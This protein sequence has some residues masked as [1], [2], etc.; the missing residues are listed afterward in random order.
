MAKDLNASNVS[1]AVP[2]DGLVNT[3]ASRAYV[4]EVASRDAVGLSVRDATLVG[5][6]LS[7]IVVAENDEDLEAFASK[8]SSAGVTV[9]QIELPSDPA[10]RSKLLAEWSGKL[11]RKNKKGLMPLLLLPLAACGG[12][13]SALTFLVSEADGNLAFDGTAIG[14]VSVEVASNGDMSFSRGG[15]SAAQGTISV[16]DVVSAPEAILLSNDITGMGISDAAKL[17]EID[18]FSANGKSIELI[19]TVSNSASGLLTVDAAFG[20][21]DASALTS[22]TGSAADLNA[23]YASAGIT[24]LGN[25]AVTVSDAAL[26]AS[27]LNTLDANTSGSVNASS[28]TSLTG[29]AAE[30]NVAYASAGITGLGNEAVTLTDGSLGA[31]TL[32]TVN[33][34]TTGVVSAASVTTLTG[35][36]VDVNA[37]YTANTA[38]EIS[39]LGNEAVTLT[40][41]SLGA[42]TLNTVNGNTTGVVNAASVTTLT[43][44]AVDVNAAYTANTAGEISG[45]GNEAVTLTDGSLSSDT[46]SSVATKTTGALNVEGAETVTGSAASISTLIGSGRVGFADDVD[47]TISAGAVVASDLI[48]MNDA[49][50]GIVDARDVTTI[51]GTAADILQILG[52]AGIANPVTFT[53]KLVAGSNDATDVTGLF[54]YDAVALVNAASVTNLTGSIAEINAVLDHQNITKPITMTATIDAGS[55]AASDLTAL[56]AEANVTSVSAFAVTTLTGTLT[57][58]NAVLAEGNIANPITMTATIDAGSVAASDLT[59]LLAEANVTSVSAAAVTSLTGTAAAVLSVLNE[60]NIT[61]PTSATVTISAG[62]H[63][64]ADLS[65]I[66]AAGG[67][68]S[69]DASAATTLTGTATEIKALYDAGVTFAANVNFVVNEAATAAQLE[70]IDGL[71][72]GTLSANLAGGETALDLSGATTSINTIVLNDDGVTV[73]GSSQTDVITVGA[74]ADTLNLGDGADVVIIDGVGHADGDVINTEGGNDQINVSGNGTITALEAITINGGADTDTLIVSDTNDFT[75]STI[76]NVEIEVRSDV[77][78]TIDQIAAAGGAIKVAADVAGDTSLSHAIT[79]KAAPGGATSVTITKLQGITSLTVDAGVSVTL[80]DAAAT[81]IATAAALAD[82]G[83]TTGITLDPTSTFEL[84]ANAKATLTAGLIAPADLKY[85]IADDT[86]SILAEQLADATYIGGAVGITVEDAIA[87]VDFA[88][89]SAARGAGINIVLDGGISDTAANLAPAGAV[90]ARLTNAVTQDPDVAITV[91]GVAPT[92]AEVNAIAGAT[93]GAVTATLSVND[94]ATLGGLNTGSGDAISVIVTD[95]SVDAGAAV[96][97]AGKTSLNVDATA[98]SEI[99][100]TVANIVAATTTTSN[101]LL[102]GDYTVVAADAGS[103]A[104]VN[105]IAAATTGVVTVTLGLNTIANLGLLATEATDAVTVVVT[106]VR[107]AASDLLAIDGKTSVAVNA[108]QVE[109]ITGTVAELSAY[110]DAFNAR[111]ISGKLAY[112]VVA[113]D[114]TDDV[115]DL[116]HLADPDGTNFDPDVYLPALTSMTGSAS[117][118]IDFYNLTNVLQNESGDALGDEAVTLT[119]TTL[120]ADVLN[121][122]DTKTTGLV[123][124]ST[125]TTLTGAAADM[126]TAYASAG[127]TGLGDEAATLSDVALDAA[128]LETLVGNTSGAINASSILTLTGAASEIIAAINAGVS[129]KAD[130][131]INVDEPASAADISTIADITTGVVT[132]TSSTTAVADLLT[133]LTTDGTTDV[134]SITVSDTSVDAANLNAI[135]AL[136]AAAAADVDFAAVTELTG[137]ADAIKT[138][139][140]ANGV[141]LTL[142]GTYDIVAS[143]DTSVADIN[144]IVGLTAGAGATTGTITATAASSDATELAGL[145]T[146]DARGDVIAITVTGSATGSELNTISG[147]TT[148]EVTA[149]GVTA[150]TGSAGAIALAVADADI[151]MSGS[152][153]VTVDAPGA[154]ASELNTIFQNTTG[155]VTATV[156]TQTFVGA[157]NLATLSI[158][159]D[160]AVPALTVTVAD[161]TANAADLTALQVKTSVNVDAT[162]TVNGIAGSVSEIDALIASAVDLNANYNLSLSNETLDI[163]DAIRLDGENG[164]GG[165]LVAAATTISGTAS[166]LAAAINSP[167]I[168]VP[169]G[170]SFVVEAEPA[171][172]ATAASDLDTIAAFA[173]AANAV[174]TSAISTVEGAAATLDNLQGYASIASGSTYAVTVNNGA[175]SDASVSAILD[176]RAETS[177]VI[178]ATVTEG[179]PATLATLNDGV[180]QDTNENDQLTISVGAVA[181][182]AADLLKI[183]GATGLTVG[184]TAATS[185]TGS[186]ADVLAALQAGANFG[187]PVSVAVTITGANAAASDINAIDALTTGGIDATAVGTLSGSSADVVSAWAAATFGA[188][189]TVTTTEGAMTVAEFNV[190]NA[191]TSGVITATIDVSTS[192]EGVDALDDLVSNAP[193]VENV[194]TIAVS[195]ADLDAQKLADLVTVTSLGVDASGV[196]SVVGDVTSVGNLNDVSEDAGGAI[197]A[198]KVALSTSLVAKLSNNSIDIDVALVE[199]G[200]FPGVFDFSAATAVTAS[201]GAWEQIVGILATDPEALTFA[202]ATATIK[203]AEAPAIVTTIDAGVLKQIHDALSTVDA[204]NVTEITGSASDLA[205]LTSAVAVPTVTLA[206]NVD[207]EP[208]EAISV[209]LANALTGLSGTGNVLATIAETDIATLKTLSAADNDLTITVADTQVASVDLLA[210]NAATTLEIDAT[211]VTRVN[212]SL[213]DALLLKADVEGDEIAGLTGARFY[214]SD[215][216]SNLVTDVMQ[217][218]NFTAGRVYSVAETYVGLASDL[219]DTGNAATFLGAINAGELITNSAFN[220]RLSSDANGASADISINADVLANL[221]PSM[222]NFEV[223][224]DASIVSQITGSAQAIAAIVSNNAI[225]LDGNY[226]V[227]LN[228]ATA[229]PADILTILNDTIGAIDADGTGVGVT[230]LIG[231]AQ[232]AADVFTARDGGLVLDFANVNVEVTDTSIAAS[233]VTSLSTSNGAGNVDI[234][235]ATLVTG[236]AAQAASVATEAPPQFIS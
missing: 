229:D 130:V 108:G 224:V 168:S 25:E 15:V 198:G 62:T 5:E 165:V 230:R 74:G 181:L 172:A 104:D 220:L 21:V 126:N 29:F 27:V 94:M 190:I 89:I 106:D 194:L 166:E 59:A 186:A 176:M 14:D 207:F 80:S 122:V 88:T 91:T 150:V 137:S 142:N 47:F 174:D 213:A 103:V 60:A 28:V 98:V 233:L 113:S 200:G 87:L 234:T 217:I 206:A 56:L 116:I 209:S 225:T 49:T 140:A 159:A 93:N 118:V 157:G 236:T 73:T 68:T 67:I 231:E 139:M 221:V 232:D 33:D 36:A 24:G 193:G 158:N 182:P 40:D 227:V 107:V 79:I 189:V 10:S 163:A 77:T 112:A 48:A 90:D 161:L 195:G 45:L 6:K 178:T 133:D 154:S 76:S 99:T 120:A 114:E 218:A 156:T 109:T 82:V 203:A 86:A 124:A 37:A 85:A 210:V 196:T 78:F 50:T 1:N 121:L 92:V 26:A 184:A 22:L 100:G 20:S 34:N 175:D 102:A 214:L 65:S 84:S 204:S 7:T 54:A 12:G 125:V 215:T 235:D 101:L 128:I 177:G 197:T 69:V 228:T 42:A 226:T 138:A 151:A 160:G 131:A 164:T 201:V 11:A 119:D 96:V 9:T 219:G 143:G 205:W 155:L 83:V 39:G 41:G 53:V 97:L 30:L 147:A 167:A 43:G 149:T 44:A 162:L 38:G 4:V 180:G 3:S 17:S 129:F 212:G 105:T 55:E 211:A 173:T 81:E 136:T 8:P 64:A 23:A 31:A 145:T 63:D 70:A 170:A 51:E 57:E 208:S 111:T 183:V 185:V 110:R 132:A 61:D 222:P 46:I 95:A 192:L 216:V 16:A 18:N 13:E 52:D 115:A 135:N 152:Y 146:T 71:T 144:L 134:I 202:A 72:T 179:D 58:I 153:S 188:G 171:G 35:D 169:A 32:N 223:D 127:L 141:S 117:D 19:D 148:S 123:D 66:L 187:D 2:V 199:L 191:A 75:G